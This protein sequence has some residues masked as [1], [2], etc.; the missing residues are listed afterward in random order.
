MRSAILATASVFA[1]CPHCE[2]ALPSPSGAPAW[3]IEDAPE[4][5][6]VT[7]RHCDGVAHLTAPWVTLHGH[8]ALKIATALRRR[9]DALDLALVRQRHELP[10]QAIRRP[11]GYEPGAG[12]AWAMWW[13]DDQGRHEV[14]VIG[15]L[16]G[17]PL[18]T[19]DLNDALRGYCRAQGW[20]LQ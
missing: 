18:V 13:Q 19:G 16:T 12:D 10:L 1:T 6:V 14:A 2:E 11:V 15:D 4:S 5:V 9:A 7:C 8:P 17:G 20:R 3:T